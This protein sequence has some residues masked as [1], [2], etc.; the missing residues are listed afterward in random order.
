MVNTTAVCLTAEEEVRVPG[1]T[2]FS[3]SDLEDSEEEGPTEDLDV[4][5][6]R[7]WQETD[8][9]VKAN[10]VPNPDVTP[11]PQVMGAPNGVGEE[12]R[13]K[14]RACQGGCGL[15]AREGTNRRGQYHRYCCPTCQASSGSTHDIR[16]QQ[17]GGL[18]PS[19]IRTS[20]TP[21][22]P[23]SQDPMLDATLA[24][25][26]QLQ[27]EEV[28]DF[29]ERSVRAKV[30]NAM[31]YVCD[32]IWG[33]VEFKPLSA[34]HT[35]SNRWYRVLAASCFR[36]CP[37]CVISCQCFRSHLQTPYSLSDVRRGWQK[38][39]LCW[40]TLFAVA[41]IVIFIYLVLA[42]G[43]AEEKDNSMIGPTTYVLNNAGAKNA[44]R[45]LEYGEWWRLITPLGLHGGLFHLIPNVLLQLRVGVVLEAVWGHAAWIT[46]YVLTG[47]YG[48][49]LS[50]AVMPDTLSIGSSG[51]L[52]GLLGAW[53]P[54]I[55]ATW[56]QTLP[57]DVGQRNSQL[58]MVLTT[59]ALMVPLSF[60]PM[61]DFAAHLGGCAM[62][63]AVGAVIFGGRLQTRNWM[64]AS[65]V[66]GVV[67]VLL[68][69]PF[70]LYWVLNEI[71]PAA[72]LLQICP[73]PGCIII[74]SSSSSTSSS[75][76][77][78]P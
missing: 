52:C 20:R 38:L 12:Y 5:L 54:F 76:T 64:I 28:N 55:L 14:P 19:T 21:R 43:F 61:V 24:M 37:C 11:R 7:R 46:I 42:E 25:A 26:M 6:A 47:V 44:A 27:M 31:C 71:E 39:I 33:E 3:T 49:L 48:S 56:N 50:C 73:P 18:T 9:G 68:L 30:T 2:Q 4:E 1:Q 23:R 34:D 72:S 63:V 67:G 40:S 13:V 15:P 16:C 74:V 66:L 10:E 65:R 77:K 22:T 45:I 62:G 36:E 29:K 51:A 58:F 70:T 35:G 78:A 69:V 8:E 41:Q 53:V 75:S 59:I 57:R 32:P 17:Q 60:L